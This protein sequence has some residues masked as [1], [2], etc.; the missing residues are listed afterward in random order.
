M[1]PAHH[2]G[3]A[4]VPEV[5]LPAV[6]WPRPA[7]VHPDDITT[8]YKDSRSPLSATA[9]RNAPTAEYLLPA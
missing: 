8:G 9:T 7:F 2:L 1:E 4:H 3:Q 5:Q 6:A